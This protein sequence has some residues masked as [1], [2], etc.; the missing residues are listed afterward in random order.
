MLGDCPV[1]RPICKGEQHQ[2]WSGQRNSARFSECDCGRRI[3]TLTSPM[4]PLLQPTHPLRLVQAGP[5][6]SHRHSH[7]QIADWIREIRQLAWVAAV[8]LLLF[9]TVG[10]PQT[11][12][13]LSNTGNRLM[14]Q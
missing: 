10:V 12:R 8:L 9:S 14:E 6:P 4:F 11:E 1:R 5:I 3:L 7:L 2:E 13:L